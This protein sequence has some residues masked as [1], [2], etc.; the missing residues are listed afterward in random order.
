MPGIEKEHVLA[1]RDLKQRFDQEAGTWRDQYRAALMEGPYNAKLFRREYVLELLG[2]GGG[3]CLD[4][5]CGAGPFLEP[6][7]RLGW[8]PAAFDFAPN[9]VAL[10]GE[11]AL[12]LGAPGAV[13]GDCTA[14][15]FASESAGG[16]ISVGLI[17]YLPEDGAFLRECLRV[18]KPGGKCV[19]TL[20]NQNCLERRLWGL[21]KKLGVEV[22]DTNYF[23]REHTLAKFREEALT[24]GFEVSGHRLCHFY[25]LT[26]PLPRFLPGAN[27]RLARV[28]ESMLSASNMD[29]L[30]ST[31]VV[32]LQKP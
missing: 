12:S 9:M 24:A 17:E 21:Y 22:V 3:V 15:P 5:G 10:A 6:L 19:V 18:L 27:G 8:R 25:P 16:I 26:W 1:L 11:E 23:F 4:L 14:L 28:M 2:P 29:R 31:L 7:S 30:A 32:A 20:R 13:R